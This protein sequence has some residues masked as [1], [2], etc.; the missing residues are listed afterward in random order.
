MKP[1]VITDFKKEYLNEII[2][3]ADKELGK[4]YVSGNLISDKNSI[5]QVAITENG[6][7]AGFSCG[8]VTKT[9]SFLKNTPHPITVN[10][11]KALLKHETVGVTKSLALR[12]DMQKQGIGTKLFAQRIN[13][14]KEKGAGAIY[15]PGW[16]TPG[17]ITSIDGI[18]R[19]FGFKKIETVKNFFYRDSLTRGYSCPVCGTPPCRCSAVVYVLEF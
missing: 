6:E 15:M 5:T 8:I 11:K 3:I 12:H 7:V 17:G 14:F 10:I 18:A 2:F 4:G 19:R 16:Q 13:S 9:K 1:I